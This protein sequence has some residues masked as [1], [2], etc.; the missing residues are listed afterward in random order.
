MDLESIGVHAVFGAV[1]AG[2]GYWAF[3]TKNREMALLCAGAQPSIAIAL[4]LWDLGATF[5]DM[6]S[7]VTAGV[8]GALSMKMYH[9][10]GSLAG[11]GHGK[12][13]WYRSLESLSLALVYRGCQ[14][15]TGSAGHVAIGLVVPGCG[16]LR[17][18]TGSGASGG[19]L[20]AGLAEHAAPELAAGTRH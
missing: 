5:G 9:M 10:V 14:G 3:K 16:A 13:G 19:C 7:S 6:T 4:S 11:M 1:A 20:G 15:R 17:I 12:D 18:G 8:Y 2:G